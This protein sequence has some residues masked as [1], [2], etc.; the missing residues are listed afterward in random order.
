MGFAPEISVY[1]TRYP[2]NVA[3]MTGGERLLREQLFPLAS[4]PGAL[5]T[6]TLLGSPVQTCVL[7]AGESERRI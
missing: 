4:F 7:L 5:R 2:A 1:G 6:L 3:A